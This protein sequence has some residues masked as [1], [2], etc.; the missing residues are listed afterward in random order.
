MQIV[1]NRTSA[2][3]FL[4]IRGGCLVLVSKICL[5][6]ISFKPICNRV[7]LRFVLFFYFVLFFFE[8]DCFIFSFILFKVKYHVY[9]RKM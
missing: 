8:Y 5:R 4:E 2:V 1:L 7:N 6:K 9:E 3:I